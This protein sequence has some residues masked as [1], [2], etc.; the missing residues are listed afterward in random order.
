MKQQ[1]LHEIY[2]YITDNISAGI[3]AVDAQGKTVIYN[4][5]MRE[6]KGIHSLEEDQFEQEMIAKIN[7]SHL[8]RVLKTCEPIK[9]YKMNFWNRVG[10]EIVTIS[11]ILPI[12]KDG[13]L[14]G[15]VEISKDITERE[16]MAYQPLRRYGQPLT[17][18]IITAVSPLMAGVIER[19]K[20][21]AKTRMPVLLYGESG[22]GKDMIAEGIHHD[23]NPENDHF[24]TLICRNDEQALIDQLKQQIDKNEQ[25]TIFCERVEYLS[26]EGQER[27]L[28]L[29]KEHLE[30]HVFI[31]SVGK[32]PIDLIEKGQLSKDLYYFFA[33]V[34]INVP[35][36]SDRKEDIKPFISDY[37]NRYRNNTGSRIQGLSAKVEQIFLDYD[38]PGNL[39]ELEVLLDDITST[40]TNETLIDFDML[41]IYFRWK[42]QSEELSDTTGS[43]FVAENEKDIRPLNVF[44]NE[45]EEYY[46]QNALKMFD[47]N[48]SQ[49]AKAL[50]LRRQSLQYRLKK[51][52]E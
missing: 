19:A 4:A 18:D 20:M 5:K 49:T 6:L 22:T 50:G 12:K 35:A 10:Q 23:L 15:A 51:F 7:D 2:K 32:D 9:N 24:I 38:W 46:I 36:L 8:Y 52:N 40:M 39:K 43:M 14:I 25:V 3:H 26:L 31:A 21:A 30:S 45:V 11:D 41:P 1:N 28:N 42:V 13:E 17:F 27:I 16:L 33:S 37:F 34:C 44:M 29:F 47:G 48:V